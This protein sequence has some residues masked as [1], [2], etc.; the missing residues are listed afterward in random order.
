MVLFEIRVNYIY[1]FI[2]YFQKLLLRN[3]QTRRKT[4]LL[5]QKKVQQLT[6]NG[7]SHYTQSTISLTFTYTAM[8]Q[9]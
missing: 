5:S 6:T 9:I 4:S 8:A 3:W 1:S 2:L 7:K